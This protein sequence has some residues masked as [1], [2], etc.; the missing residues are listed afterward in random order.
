MG[1]PLYLLTGLQGSGSTL[2]GWCF[3]QHPELDGILDGPYHRLPDVATIDRSRLRFCKRT[4]A[5]FR[6]TEMVEFFEDFGFAVRPILVVRDVRFV[7]SSL[8]RKHYGRNSVTSRHPPLRMRFRRFREDWFAA[9][10]RGWP[11]LRYESFVVDPEPVLRNVCAQVGLTW[12]RA[13][14]EWPRP[15]Q[16]ILDAFW[17]NATFHRNR[18]SDLASSIRLDPLDEPLTGISRADLGWLNESFESFLDAHE[19]P[20]GISPPHS[21]AHEPAIARYANAGRERFLWPFHRLA[22]WVTRR[23]ALRRAAVRIQSRSWFPRRGARN[24]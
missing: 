15:P 23:Q 19:Y 5:T 13:M 24:L 17:G 3:L 9:R 12:D 22:D 7:W 11:I 6:T 18:G 4:I 21:A 20:P 8:S 10:E 16:D 1:P 2:I 14:V